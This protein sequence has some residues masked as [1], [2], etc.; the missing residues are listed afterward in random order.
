MT[1]WQT[2]QMKINQWASGGGEMIFNLLKAIPI[3]LLVALVAWF[4]L[5]KLSSKHESIVSRKKAAVGLSFYVA[6]LLLMGILQRPFGEI[7]NIVW[8]PFVTPGGSFIVVL[9]A[10]ANCIIFIPLGKLD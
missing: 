10:M 9:Y 6:L 5:T 4:V 7:R 2:L 8:T 3:S 1:V